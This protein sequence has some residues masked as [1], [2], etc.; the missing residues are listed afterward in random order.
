[1]LD[2]TLAELCGVSTNQAVSRNRDRFPDDFLI[3]ARSDDWKYLRS[4][5]VTLGKS[6]ATLDADTRRQFDVVYEQFSA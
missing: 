1:M 6:V 4:Q 2:E 3:E 5:F